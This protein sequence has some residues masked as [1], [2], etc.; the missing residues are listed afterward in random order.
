MISLPPCFGHGHLRARRAVF[1]F[2]KIQWSGVPRSARR[3]SSHWPKAPGSVVRTR[4]SSER[5][6][7]DCIFSPGMPRTHVLPAFDPRELR[8][9]ATRPTN[10]VRLVQQRSAQ[11]KSAGTG[12]DIPRAPDQVLPSNPG[13]HRVRLS[14]HRHCSGLLVAT[15]VDGLNVQSAWK[16]A[17]QCWK[18]ESIKVLAILA[19]SSASSSPLFSRAASLS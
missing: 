7:A 1:C 15:R 9:W 2:A 8:V 18:L 3:I 14:Q 19:N 12:R 13:Q 5:A 17:I 4:L 11:P 16:P 10:V 6:C